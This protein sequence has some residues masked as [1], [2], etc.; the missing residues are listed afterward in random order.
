MRRDIVISISIPAATIAN[1]PHRAT[2]SPMS[3]TYEELQSFLWIIV[4]VMVIVVLYHVLFIVVDLRKILHR[5]ERLSSEVEVM[6]MKP[7]AMAEQLVEWL[8][9]FL[10]AKSKKKPKKGSGEKPFPTLPV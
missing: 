1:H 8:K 2:L 10:E 3:L 9:E 7:L 5:F 4:A 6:I